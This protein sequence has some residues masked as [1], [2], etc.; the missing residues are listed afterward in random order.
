MEKLAPYRKAAASFLIG[1]ATF[2]GVVLPLLTDGVVTEQDI[3]AVI[4][5]LAG[6]LGGTAVVYQVPNQ[7]TANSVKESVKQDVR[8]I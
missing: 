4:L 5:A 7:V 8:K 1:L 6:W 3:V 2:L